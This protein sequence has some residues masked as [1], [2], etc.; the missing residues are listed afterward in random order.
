MKRFCHA[1][2]GH[3]ALFDSVK[4]KPIP[5]LN[6]VGFVEREPSFT[7]RSFLTF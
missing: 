6:S 5:R 3:Y 7:N 1:R 2:F 4:T